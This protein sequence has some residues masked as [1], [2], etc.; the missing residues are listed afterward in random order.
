MDTN[1]RTSP[2]LSLLRFRVPRYRYF[3]ANQLKQCGPQH[4]E[5]MRILQACEKLNIPTSLWPKFAFPVIRSQSLR[6][7]IPNRPEKFD[8][9]PFDPLTQSVKE[10]RTQCHAAFDKT[11]DEYSAKFSAKFNEFLREGLYVKIPQTR[12]TTPLDLRYEWAARRLCY[13]TPYK[14]LEEQGYT[15]ERIKQ[16]VLQILKN[17][18]LGKRKPTANAYSSLFER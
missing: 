15:Y 17:A 4:W 2:N 7:F 6:M 14:E 12:D 5:R 8:L 16:S 3:P 18:G 11:L 9:P 1:E 13:R 10:W